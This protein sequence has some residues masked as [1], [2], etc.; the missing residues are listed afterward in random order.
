MLYS[1]IIGLVHLWPWP[2]N[3]WRC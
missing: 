3:L 1:E 2:W